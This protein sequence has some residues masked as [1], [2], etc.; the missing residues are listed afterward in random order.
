[1]IKEL[2]Y[3]TYQTFPA[4]T[5]N[6]IQTISNIKYFV[7]NEVAVDLY[8]PLR[9]RQSDGDLNKLKSYYSFSENFNS[10]GIKHPYPHG[11]IKFLPGLWFH[12]SHFL[13]SNH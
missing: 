4:E 5:A 6:S 7:K 8:F 11:K 2:V 10:I 13:W 3:I 1:M 9:D 12:I